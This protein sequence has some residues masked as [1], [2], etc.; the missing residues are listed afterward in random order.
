MRGYKL[1]MPIFETNHRTIETF[2]WHFKGQSWPSFSSPVKFSWS[3]SI[4][5]GWNCYIRTSNDL[6]WLFSVFFL[7][8]IANSIYPISIQTFILDT[9]PS[10]S[11]KVLIPYYEHAITLIM[12]GRQTSVSTWALS[13]FKLLFHMIEINVIGSFKTLILGLLPCYLLQDNWIIIIL[14]VCFFPLLHNINTF[15]LNG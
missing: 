14:L 11:K 9:L 15:F 8:Y 4:N 10:T 2:I 6:L 13:P 3:W 12:L 1:D 5:P 7:V